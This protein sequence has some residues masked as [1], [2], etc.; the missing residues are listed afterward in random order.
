MRALM[1][2][3]IVFLLWAQDV[4]RLRVDDRRREEAESTTSP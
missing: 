3:N 1:G 2:S 4:Y